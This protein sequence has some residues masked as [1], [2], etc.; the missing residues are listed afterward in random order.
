MKTKKSFKE[1]IEIWFDREMPAGNS[2]ILFE[3]GAHKLRY[4]S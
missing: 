1:L 3:L 2:H 4:L